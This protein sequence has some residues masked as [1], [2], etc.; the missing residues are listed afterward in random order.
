MAGHLDK[1]LNKLKNRVN[2][3][4]ASLLIIDGRIGMGKT[5][6]AVTVAERYQG[7]PIDINKQLGVGG[8]DFLKKYKICIEE[9]LE[10]LIYDE[11]GDFNK[12]GSLTTFNNNINRIFETFRTFRIFIIIVL[13]FFGSLDRQLY[14]N[15]IPRGLI[16]IY[17]KKDKDFTRVRVYGAYKTHLL[18]KRIQYNKRDID[19][20]CYNKVYPNF[21]TTI[22]DLPPL[23]AKKLDEISTESKNITTSKIMNK[24]SLEIDKDKEESINKLAEV[25]SFGF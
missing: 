4:L 25:L 15:G 24:V 12:R 19:Q 1:F 3:G 17:Y 9:K 5:S 18:L 8:E 13:P 16:N 23:K 2:N 21:I 20:L 7:Y 11:A 14:V 10:V 22:K 6:T